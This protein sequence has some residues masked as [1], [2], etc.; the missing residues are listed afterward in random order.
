VVVGCAALNKHLGIKLL[1]VQQLVEALRIISEQCHEL[2][3]TAAVKPASTTPTQTRRV[4]SDLCKRLLLVTSSS[5]DS[6]S[7]SLGGNGGSGSSSSG[8]SSASATLAPKCGLDVAY[9]MLNAFLKSLTGSMEW[10]GPLTKADLQE[11]VE[12]EAGQTGKA[13]S[14]AVTDM[15]QNLLS[16][17]K[18]SDPQQQPQQ[19]AAIRKVCSG[20]LRLTGVGRPGGADPASNAAQLLEGSEPLVTGPGA[21]AAAAAGKPPAKAAAAAG[22]PPAKAAAAAAAGKSPVKAAAAAAAGKPP[23]QDAADA[24]TA[25]LCREYCS[26]DSFDC[27]VEVCCGGS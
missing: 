4:A 24:T 26:L 20:L 23:V 16:S 5:A 15:F 6:S 17:A 3:P 7:G 18:S 13:V 1:T 21:A 8:S 9:D 19:Y 25:A 11:A 10:A 12:V 27:D 22:K 2:Q 14:A